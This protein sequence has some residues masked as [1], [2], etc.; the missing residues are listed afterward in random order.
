MRLRLPLALLALLALAIVAAAPAA[1]ARKPRQAKRLVAFDSCD[2]L[3]TYAGRNNP[4]APPRVIAPPMSPELPISGGEDGGAVPQPAPPAAPAPAVGAPDAGDGGEVGEDTSGT[5]NQEAGV[6][7]P[8]TVKTDGET[9]FALSGDALHAV[10]VT[11]DGAPRLLD[12]IRFLESSPSSMLLRGDTLLVLGSGPAGARMTQVDVSDPAAMLVRRTQ[13]V[14]GAVVDARRV[15]RSA[16]VVV[17]SHPDAVYAEPELRDA[18]RGWLPTSTLTF[19]RS[20]R[21]VTRKA[22]RCDDVRKPRSFA[23]PGVLTV[24]TVDMAEG[25]PAVDADAVMSG[26]ELVY[27][28]ASSLYVATQRYDEGAYEPGTLVHRFDITEPE[29][30]TYAASGFVPGTLLS[31]FALS[32]DKGILRAASTRGFGTDSVVT[33]LQQDG[34]LLVR[35]GSVE[36]LGK[37]E[38]IYAVRFMGDV[39]YVVTFRQTDP[40]YTI[41][42][43][44]PSAPRVRGELKIPGYSAY[45]HPVG[46]GLLLGVGQDA[47]EE[48][49]R[50]QGLQLSLFDVSDL[51][52]PARLQQLKLGDRFSSSAVEWNHHAFL[53]WPATK[54]A[55]LP[56]DTQDFA[57]AGG[58]KVDRAGGIAELGRIGHPPAFAG[59]WAPPIERASVIR[60]RLFTIS[61]GGVKMSGLDTLADAGWAAF[62]D[63]P[64]V[65]P[66]YDGPIPTGPAVDGPV[67]MP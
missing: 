39:G 48:T 2:Q 58:F 3:I 25:L 32:E 11:G 30:T 19:R 26:G 55:M 50:V 4:V 42:L 43:S 36:G 21:Q 57:G 62:P 20:G 52:K 45:L 27:G 51:A 37:G 31:Q 7:E 65:Y 16:R 49:G 61:G 53:W 41:D 17:A 38:R 67:A 18:A 1:D 6:H 59:G 34:G 10:A 66:P 13:D 28:S 44:D 63:A 8:D 40:L 64:Q 23:G 46:D 5:N 22:V 12:S 9:L 15:G 60:D 54:L 47:D 24:Y 35:R 56:I 33:T 14:D 29:R